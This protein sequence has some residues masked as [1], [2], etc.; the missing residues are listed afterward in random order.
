VASYFIQF[1]CKRHNPSKQVVQVVKFLLK[2][3][4]FLVYN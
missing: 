3:V 4:E 2:T 1:P